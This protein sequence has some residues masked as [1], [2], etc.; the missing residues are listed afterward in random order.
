MEPLSEHTQPARPVEM[1]AD[2][3]L[4]EWCAVVSHDRSIA[5][6][7]AVLQTAIV[8]ACDD[9]FREYVFAAIGGE[10]RHHRN[11]NLGGGRSSAWDYWRGMA[12]SGDRVALI[13]DAVALFEDGSW[14]AGYGGDAWGTC[15]RV[16]LSRET[17]ALDSRTFVDRVFSLQHNSGS[18]LDKVEWSEQEST[19][20]MRVI[21]NAHDARETG[22]ATLYRYASE[23]GRALLLRTAW[24]RH[25]SE[26]QRADMLYML[27]DCDAYNRRSAGDW[28]AATWIHPH[29]SSGDDTYAAALEQQQRCYAA[30]DYVAD[31]VRSGASWWQQYADES[32]WQYNARICAAWQQRCCWQI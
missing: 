6:D 32:A 30:A 20:Y 28:T 27:E 13:R 8:A 15:A 5:R 24:E 25:T 12:A 26:Q 14:T 10:L 9:A 7:A 4:S 18:L 3:Y 1:M 31:M 17:G 19:Y 2:F 21:G 11:V 29:N 16:L 23:D 22:L